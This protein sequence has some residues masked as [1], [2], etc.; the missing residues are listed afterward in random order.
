MKWLKRLLIALLVLIFLSAVITII[1]I[2]PASKRVLVDN[3]QSSTGARVEIQK[4]N[5]GVLRA[6][7]SITGLTIFNKAEFGAGLFLEVKEFYT[8][9][10]RKLARNG[11]LRLKVLRLD[12]QTLVL[13]RNL[14]D[15]WNL[16]G[17]PQLAKLHRAGKSNEIPDR[18]IPFPKLAGKIFEGAD[19]VD[20]S[21]N[22]IK[23]IDLG[24]E[25][26]TATVA[27]GL[28]NLR[29]EN[30]NS[31][32]DLRKKILPTLEKSLF[33]DRLADGISTVIGP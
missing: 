20:L 26:K 3:I 16:P 2:N 6:N 30:V 8:E 29:L 9:Y 33:M 31:P 19:V 11:S 4:V 21:F 15:Q 12:I 27:V 17:I 24:A 23:I 18:G 32:D 10:D 22:E 28:K 1:L 13:V 14:D 7:A 25:G 5:V